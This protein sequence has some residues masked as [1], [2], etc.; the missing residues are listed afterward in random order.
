MPEVDD[1]IKEVIGKGDEGSKL[2]AAKC[3]P[4]L[5]NSEYV[6]V[7]Q[8]GMNGI[9]VL[10]I[11]EGFQLVVHSAGGD[12]HEKNL[13]RH[14]ASLVDKLAEQAETINAVPVGFADV[15]DTSTE[16]KPVLNLIADALVEK[17]DRYG[18]PIMN[19]EFAILG[20]RVN[21]D[22]NV[23]GTMISMVPKEFQFPVEPV[24]GIFEFNETS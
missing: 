11:P 18:L 24:K 8:Q 1:Y 20:A 10:R 23:S 7:L 19:G 12:P 6:E 2:L 5:K 9:A 22:A 15:I 21:C 17:A 3:A 13:S 4:T 14:A 16:S